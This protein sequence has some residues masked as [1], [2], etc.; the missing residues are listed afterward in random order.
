MSAED[1]ELQRALQIL[2]APMQT[3]MPAP[4]NEDAELQRALSILDAPQAQELSAFDKALQVGR[5]Y[6]ASAPG[7]IIDLL[8][9]KNLPEPSGYLSPERFRPSPEIASQSTEQSPEQ[10]RD[11]YQKTDKNSFPELHAEK[12]FTGLYDKLAGKDLTPTDAAGRI[13]QG[14]GEFFSPA[15]IVG[16][17][18]AALTSGK[19]LLGMGKQ[20]LKNAA[21]ASAGSA[22]VHAPVHLT[23]EGGAPRV[24]EDLSRG[25]VGSMAG[26]AAVSPKATAKGISESAKSLT[27]KIMSMGTN[28]EKE[29]LSLAK[30]H[31]IE[32]PHNVG[33]GTGMGSRLQNFIANN[34]LSRNI[35][36]SSRYKGAY[37]KADKAMTT[38][39]KDT[40]KNMSE[41]E[42]K[43]HEASGEFRHHVKQEESKAQ[44]A[45]SKLYDDSRKHLTENDKVVPTHTQEAFGELN[46]ILDTPIRSADNK[47]V[48]KHLAELGESW[49]LFKPGDLKRWENSQNSGKN[50]Q[51]MMN[52]Y[53][54]AFAKGTLKEIPT[55]E[56]VKAVQGINGIIGSKDTTGVKK[57]LRGLKG[58]IEKDLGTSSNKGFLEAHKAANE[59][60]KENIGQRFR[61]KKSRS[62]LRQEGPVDA[63]SHLNSVE[64]INQ[65]E[66]MA[67]KSPEGIAKLNAL[68]KQKATELFESAFDGGMENGK[69]QQGAFAKIFEKKSGKQELIERLIGKKQYK[70]LEEISKISRSFSEHGKDLLNSSHSGSTI[71]NYAQGSAAATAIA[72]AMFSGKPL[73]S[74]GTAAGIVLT[75]Y[76]MSRVMSN[77][78]IVRRARVFALARQKGNNKYA[79]AVMKDLSKAIDRELGS[80]KGAGLK[81]VPKKGDKDE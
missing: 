13:R 12:N 72:S 19:A 71:Y 56:L 57:L 67:G 77:P 73:A 31:G 3:E 47:A 28:P 11:I 37:D 78:D 53:K 45:A 40:V 5:G 34:Y 65:L 24:V 52:K 8:Q 7:S 50:L 55:E 74:L 16:K 14:A 75:P 9:G 80:I 22:A 61:G 51:E 63:Y 4:N 49:G 41:S 26:R 30:K 48:T 43:P 46:K 62:I 1:L 81:N 79:Q 15:G 42:L 32:L 10:I 25:I 70:D 76:M 23:Q 33:T 59:F 69:L 36:S 66:K 64:G 35:F 21:S 44:K 2:D 27:A 38:K 29:V 39:V 20:F 18:K 68:K 17:G 58:A 54:E 60:Y 6:L